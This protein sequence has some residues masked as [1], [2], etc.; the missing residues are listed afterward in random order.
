MLPG[1]P[2]SASP[3]P[4]VDFPRGVPRSGRTA[5]PVLRQ[6]LWNTTG[7]ITTGETELFG[8][9]M[10]GGG[11][12]RGQDSQ[13]LR[14]EG[15]SASPLL[16][17]GPAPLLTRLEEKSRLCRRAHGAHPG[18]AA[19]TAAVEAAERACDPASLCPCVRVSLCIA[20]RCTC[21]SPCSTARAR[22]E[23]RGAAVCPQPSVPAARPRALSP[24]VRERAAS[25]RPGARRSVRAVPQGP[26]GLRCVPQPLSLLTR[27]SSQ[28]NE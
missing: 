23:P 28:R 8:G 25:V 17:P 18:S 7:N 5:Q 1:Q 12:S 13:A 9:R 11:A 24:G 27:L 20:P 21:L 15:P 3:L 16:L 26:H 14:P 6:L 22:A 4:A 19:G 2:G 10:Q